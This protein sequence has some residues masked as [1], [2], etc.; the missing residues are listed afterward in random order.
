MKSSIER[1]EKTIAPLITTQSI[2]KAYTQRMNDFCFVGDAELICVSVFC[3]SF[4]IFVHRHVVLLQKY[5]KTWIFL[6]TKKTWNAII[7]VQ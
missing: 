3:V 4:L 5:K 2:L 1:I 7:E 6:L